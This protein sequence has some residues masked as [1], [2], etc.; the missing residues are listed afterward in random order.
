MGSSKAVEQK[1][2]EFP[3]GRLRGYCQVCN[4]YYFYRNHMNTNSVQIKQHHS[5]ICQSCGYDCAR[6]SGRGKKTAP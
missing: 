1:S 5:G 6:I 2:R 3:A 4:R